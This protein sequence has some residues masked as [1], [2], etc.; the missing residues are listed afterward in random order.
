MRLILA[1]LFFFLISFFSSLFAVAQV[2]P[3][4]ID[5]T[6]YPSEPRPGQSVT[7]TAQSFGMDLNSSTITWTYNGTTLSVGTGKTSVVFTAPSSSAVATLSVSASGQGGTASSSLI[8]RSA[9]VDVIWEAIDSYTP[10]FYKGKALAPIGGKIRVTAI[11]SATAPKTLSYS[12]QYNG[13]AVLNQSGSNKTSIT[14]KTD[15]LGTNESFSVRA[16]GGS[17]TGSG[18]TQVQLRDPQILVYQKSNGFIDYTRGSTRDVYITTPGVTL[19]AEPF[20]F[21]IINSVDKSVSLGFVLDGQ[22]FV[23]TSNA[24]ELSITRPDTTGDS[25]FSV[26][27]TSLR[28]RLQTIKRSFTLHF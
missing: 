18:S 10:P 28:E 2:L 23:G 26:T 4:D 20:N 8:I 22:S 24:Q 27:A 3:Q 25:P 16:I 7:A 19:R 21:S 12:W 9:S 6:L 1:S 14:I 13:D 11:P 15:V 5:I 17:F